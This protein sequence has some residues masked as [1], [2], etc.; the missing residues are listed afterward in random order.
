LIKR[1]WGWQIALIGFATHLLLPNAEAP[2]VIAMPSES[3]S[4]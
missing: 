1:P 2:S 3:P 4:N